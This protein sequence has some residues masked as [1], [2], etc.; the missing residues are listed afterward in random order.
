MYSVQYHELSYQEN[1]VLL[2]IHVLFLFLVLCAVF[3]TFKAAFSYFIYLL[4]HR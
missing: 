4:F 1:H 2:N 3:M